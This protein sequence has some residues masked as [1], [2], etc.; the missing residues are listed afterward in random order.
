[1]KNILSPELLCESPEAKILQPFIQE[2]F[3][4]GFEETPDYDKLR[5]YLVK[6]VLDLNET[7]NKEYDWNLAFAQGTN[8]LE[9]CPANISSESLRAVDLRVAEEDCAMFDGLEESKRSDDCEMHS[10]EY[11]Q[12][13]SPINGFRSSSRDNLQRKM[14]MHGGYQFQHNTNQEVMQRRVIQPKEPLGASVKMIQG[15]LYQ[16]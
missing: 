3:N 16:E 14:S 10:G 11:D 12:N 5:F 15:Q 8:E 7:P 4:L 1:L 9:E 6:G 13:I 2:I